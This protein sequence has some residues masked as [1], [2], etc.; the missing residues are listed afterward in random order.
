MAKV[1]GGQLTQVTS[2]SHTTATT[3][4]AA[5]AVAAAGDYNGAVAGG[6]NVQRGLK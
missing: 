5:A 2:L 4:A 6:E 3:A 1:T